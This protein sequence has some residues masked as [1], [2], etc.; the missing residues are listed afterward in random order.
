MM[1]RGGQSSWSNADVEGYVE[2]EKT[3]MVKTPKI[4]EGTTDEYET[5]ANGNI[6]YENK[7]GETTH[8]YYKI[9][10]VDTGKHGIQTST[11]ELALSRAKVQTATDKYA[12]ATGEGAS[13]AISYPAT[14]GTD[15]YMECVLK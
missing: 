13:G 10:L 3:N 12:Y 1:E 6:V 8:T 15:K 14:T 7:P 9:L 4:K 11:D 5:D 2:W